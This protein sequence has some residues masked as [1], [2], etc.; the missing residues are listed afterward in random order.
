M[1]NDLSLLPNHI[2]NERTRNLSAAITR[3]DIA[4]PLLSS[5]CNAKGI[6]KTTGLKMT[7]RRPTFEK[8]LFSIRWAMLS[9]S[10]SGSCLIRTALCCKQKKMRKLKSM[11]LITMSGSLNKSRAK[12]VSLNEKQELL[13]SNNGTIPD[14]THR[15]RQDRESTAVLTCEALV[16][17]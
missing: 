5:K 17:A 15:V 13:D 11:K 9:F 12:R 14:I 2:C 4:V 16:M 10:P 3:H 7:V 1:K 8:R 6:L